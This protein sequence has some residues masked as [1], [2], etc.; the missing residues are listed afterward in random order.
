MGEHKIAPARLQW[1]GNSDAHKPFGPKARERHRGTVK[2]SQIALIVMF[3]LLVVVAL[4]TEDHFKR[5]QDA[6]VVREDPSDPSA[7]IFS[8]RGAVEYPMSEKLLDTWREYRGAADRVIIDLHSEG[9]AVTEGRAVIKIIEDIKRSHIVE[10]RVGPVNYCLSM[11]VPIYL[12]GAVRRASPSARFMFHEPSS[13]DSVTGE[14]VDTPGF[15]QRWATNRFV[16]R[17]FETSEMDPAWRE[18]LVTE[19]RG[20]DVWKTARELV[21]ERANVVQ[22]LM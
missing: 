22:E 13:R 10:T 17:Y 20:K 11:C 4:R 21:D 18:K 1:P 19:W 16:A 8:W 6:F 3:A 12:Q 2:P 15:E 5:S 7:V 14:R 9:G